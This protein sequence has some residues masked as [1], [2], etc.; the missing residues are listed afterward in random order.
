AGDL[1]QELGLERAVRE[2]GEAGVDRGRGRVQLARD[3]RAAHAS[4]GELRLSVPH[5]TGVA[6][7]GPDEVLK[8]AGEVQEE[9]AGGVLDSRR[10]RPD[11]GVVGI[12]VELALQRAE[13]SQ[14]ALVKGLL[15]HIGYRKGCREDRQR[16]L[17]F[18][19]DD[20]RFYLSESPSAMSV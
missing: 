19:Q 5:V 13:L 14:Y 20:R 12:G 18:A 15:R 4:T 11:A 6:E 16:I 7:L 1:L 3:L 8:I 10:R 2:L 17:R 9:G